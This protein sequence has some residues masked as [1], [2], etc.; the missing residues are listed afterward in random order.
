MFIVKNFDINK[1]KLLKH[2]EYKEFLTNYLLSCGL[3]SKLFIITLFESKTMF[4]N[5][6]KNPAILIELGSNKGYEYNL[7]L[8]FFNLLSKELQIKE[9]NK[10]INE[11]N[12][13]I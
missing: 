3:S 4:E 5:Y 8:N 9:I 13:I 6:V 2:T 1:F 7:L 12:I 10:F 11:F